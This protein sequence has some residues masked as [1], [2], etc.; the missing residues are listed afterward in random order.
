MRSLWDLPARA[1]KRLDHSLCFIFLQLDGV[2]S[3]MCHL[4]P[5]RASSTML[6]EGWGS[7]LDQACTMM[8]EGKSLDDLI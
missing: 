1:I 7:T 6:K 3:S 8:P 5:L 4:A 2:I